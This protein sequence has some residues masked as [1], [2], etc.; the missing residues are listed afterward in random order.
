MPHKNWMTVKYVKPH[1]IN[2]F[3]TMD[4]NKEALGQGQIVQNSESRQGDICRIISCDFWKHADAWHHPASS[5]KQLGA[6][7]EPK[8]QRPAT[9]MAMASPPNFVS[10]TPP[11]CPDARPQL[12]G[13]A[14]DRFRFL[15]GPRMLRRSNMASSENVFF[16]FFSCYYQVDPGISPFS[17]NGQRFF[18]LA[19]CE[20]S[21]VSAIFGIHSH[22]C[23]LAFVPK[24]PA[25]TSIQA[26]VFLFW[27]LGKVFKY[28]LRITFFWRKVKTLICQEQPQA[29]V[30][31]SQR[32]SYSVVTQIYEQFG[33]GEKLLLAISTM[34]ISKYV[35][36]NR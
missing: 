9:G 24:V 30:E 15:L 22:G 1:Q 36:K 33:H 8:Q 16:F 12:D 3:D 5:W 2:C 27:T 18:F 17:A 26:T 32:P 10:S 31:Y 21:P 25:K 35:R 7:T 23:V 34:I 28:N 6:V 29:K 13:T 19:A 4:F 20:Y 14:G 11:P